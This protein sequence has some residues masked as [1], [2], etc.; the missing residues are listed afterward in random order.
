MIGQPFRLELMRALLEKAEDGNFDFLEVFEVREGSWKVLEKMQ[1]KSEELYEDIKR[2]KAEK[3]SAKIAGGRKK[4][5]KAT[6]QDTPAAAQ[7]KRL[8]KCYKVQKVKK[9]ASCA[10]LLRRHVRPGGR[11]CVNLR[12]GGV[13]DID[14]SDESC[15]PVD[16]AREKAPPQKRKAPPPRKRRVRK[17]SEI[18]K[19]D[20]HQSNTAASML[21]TRFASICMKCH[22]ESR[23]DSSVRFAAGCQTQGSFDQNVFV[24]P[25]EPAK[26]NTVSEAQCGGAED[27]TAAKDRLLHRAYAHA[28][29][30]WQATPPAVGRRYFLLLPA[31]NLGALRP[32]HP[33]I[34]YSF[35]PASKVLYEFVPSHGGEDRCVVAWSP[36]CP[37]VNALL[38]TVLP[39]PPEHLEVEAAAASPETSPLSESADEDSPADVIDELI[40]DAA[41]E[42]GVS[43][44]SAV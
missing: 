11:P 36:S 26:E 1:K 8:K 25:S 43:L 6:E 22:L 27:P 10:A 17:S 18:P 44:D 3:S 9:P 13:V 23:K 15:C 21:Q 38:W 24:E 39:L 31:G 29:G 32:G 37:E 19:P 16:A 35:D 20:S 41:A 7:L 42:A 2:L 14:S 33:A 12:L 40:R 4:T 28:V 5:V 34:L 30:R